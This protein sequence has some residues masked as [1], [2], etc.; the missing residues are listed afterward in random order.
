VFVGM[1]QRWMSSP[2]QPNIE[3]LSR[4]LTLQALTDPHK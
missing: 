4:T 3:D 2:P 1:I